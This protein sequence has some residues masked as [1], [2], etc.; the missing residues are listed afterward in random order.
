MKNNILVKII[1]VIVFGLLLGTC[2]FKS[3]ESITEVKQPIVKTD[4]LEKK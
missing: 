4:S 3:T 2:D 1:T